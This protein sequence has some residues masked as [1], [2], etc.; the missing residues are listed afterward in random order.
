MPTS[1]LTQ[2]ALIKMLRDELGIHVSTSMVHAWVRAKMPTS[3]ACGK[4]PRFVWEQVRAWV[5]SNR[6]AN[7]VVRSA[8]DLAWK[9]KMNAVS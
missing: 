3:P 5:L 7:S 6:E 2:R 4:K 9:R 1:L 8:Q